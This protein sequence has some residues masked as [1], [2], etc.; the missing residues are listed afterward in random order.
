MKKPGETVSLLSGKVR[1]KFIGD[2]EVEATA[3][4]AAEWSTRMRIRFRAVVSPGL[5][6]K[7]IREADLEGFRVEWL[8]HSERPYFDVVVQGLTHNEDSTEFVGHPFSSA[9]IDTGSPLVSAQAHITNFHDFLGAA[10]A[11][12]DLGMSAA[13]ASWEHNGWAFIVDKVCDKSLLSDIKSKDG[14]GI[15]HVAQVVRQNG[16]SFPI[17]EASSLLYNDIHWAL[18]FCRGFWVGPVL[19]VGYDKAGSPAWRMFDQT[20]TRAGERVMSWFPTKELGALDEFMVGFFDAWSDPTWRSTLN[21][22]I[23][24]YINANSNGGQT[25]FALITLQPL[26]EAFAWKLLVDAHCVGKREFE[27]MAAAKKMRKVLEFAGLTDTCIPPELTSLLQFVD[28]ANLTGD[29]DG[30]RVLTWIR[31]KLVHPSRSQLEKLPKSTDV[32]Y[33]VIRLAMTYAE[34][35]IL[36]ACNYNGMYCCRVRDRYPVPESVPWDGGRP[37]L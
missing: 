24:A 27:R 34:L 36:K 25:D 15:T 18:A 10:V 37:K 8:D 17:Q 30:P 4:L 29:V 23:Y 11:V 6:I 22:S 28:E 16:D 33:D 2:I 1:V 21:L 26:F 7:E 12:G 32:Y 13:R 31:N 3:E 9:E 5:S 19:G 20:R 35:A 14:I